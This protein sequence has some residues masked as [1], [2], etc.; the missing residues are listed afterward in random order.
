[1]EI[2]PFKFMEDSQFDY[3]YFNNPLE[4]ELFRKYFK[5][6]KELKV[7]PFGENI[8]ESFTCMVLCL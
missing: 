8:R 3:F 2:L 6:P 7:I 5:T 1:M 4:E